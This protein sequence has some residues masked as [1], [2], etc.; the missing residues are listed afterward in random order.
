MRKRVGLA[1]TLVTNPSIIL[2]DEPTTGLDP[3]TARIVFELM[4][5]MQQQIHATSVIISHD[6]EIFKYVDFVA[7]LHEGKIQ[8]FG[9]ADTIWESD[10]PYIYQFIRGLSKGPIQ[11]EIT[12]RSGRER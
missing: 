9:P 2:Y 6:V 4:Y 7:M 3:I 1:R 5:N 12:H 8:Y 11:Q 10:N